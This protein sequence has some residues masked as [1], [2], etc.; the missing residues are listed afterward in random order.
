MAGL[1]DVDGF[2]EAL[3]MRPDTEE[4]DARRPRH[5]RACRSSCLFNIL[6]MKERVE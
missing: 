5:V 6:G 4:G 2:G 3:K 1:Y